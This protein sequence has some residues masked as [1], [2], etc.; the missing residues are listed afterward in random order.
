MPEGTATVLMAAARHW[1]AW[2]GYELD[3]K[4]TWRRRVPGHGRAPTR[5]AA[6][7]VLEQLRPHCTTPQHR[8][9]WRAAVVALESGLRGSSIAELKKRHGRAREYIVPAKGG[10]TLRAPL[11]TL[12]ANLVLQQF[13]EDEGFPE[14]SEL[15]RLWRSLRAHV[16]EAK[17]YT[18]HTFRHTFASHLARDGQT[19]LP[20]I[21]RILGHA[22]I[23][24][25]ERYLSALGIDVQ[26]AIQSLEPE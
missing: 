2:N 18:L 19:G 23:K 13:E 25:T 24:T 15:R 4:L 3:A 10:R 14:P 21:Q 7:R 17:R 5:A 12:A 8:T 11:T 20:T 16:P 1:A 22:S 9:A 26:K 6:Q